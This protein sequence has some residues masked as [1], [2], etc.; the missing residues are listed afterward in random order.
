MP[1]DTASILEVLRPVQD[2]ELQKSL[3]ELNMIRNVAIDGGKVSFTLVLTTPACPLREFIVEDCQKAVKQLPGVESVAVDVTAETPQ[4]KALPDRQG[5]EGVKNIIAVSSGKGGVGKSTVAVNIAVA[6]AHLGAKVGLLDAD[7]YGPNAPTMLGLN[8]AQVTVQGANGEIL[9]PAF[10]HG[11]KMV[12]MGFLIN[13]DQ[14]VIWRGPMLNGII[15]QFLYQVNWG[16]L[17]Y[18]I[19]DMPPGTGDAQLT[20][21]QSVPLAGA[22][23]VTT[24]QTVSLIDARRGLKMFQQLG[25]R[26]LGIVENMS[27]FIPPD[28]PDRSYDLFGSGGGEKTSQ[29]LG[30]PLLGCVPLEISLRE[31]GDTGVPVVLGQPESASA[32]ALIAIARQVAAKVS[33]AAYS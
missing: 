15:R 16:N 33:V 22:V 5:V 4:Q 1:L 21:I 14:P 29:E 8:D 11:I 32:K 28:Q 9:E 13:P 2:P 10:N 7:I 12:S 30:I 3:V 25:A 27:Y 24:P 20:L 23:I 19:V 31:G 17:D 6:L 18:L 26:V